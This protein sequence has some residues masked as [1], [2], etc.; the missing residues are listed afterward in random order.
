MVLMN[1]ANMLN[2]LVVGTGDLSELALGWC[3][4][5]G[6]HMSMYAVNTGVPK[7]LITFLI[8]FVADNWAEEDVAFTL[9]DILETPVSPELLPPDM[10]GKISQRTEEMIG[11]YELHDFFLYQM[12]RCGFPPEKILFLAEQVFANAYDE[13]TIRK[14]LRVFITRFFAHQFKRSCMP[15]GP[16]VGTIALSPRGDWRMP[17]DASGEEWLRRLD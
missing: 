6:D 10:E 13:K 12:V 4:Y 11:P 5:N 3:T 7:T 15:D 17:S 9:R 8:E 16:K 2:A 1:K 14:W